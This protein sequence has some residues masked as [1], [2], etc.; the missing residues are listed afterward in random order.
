M[1]SPNIFSSVDMAQQGHGAA[2]DS[3]YAL[4]KFDVLFDHQKGLCPNIEGNFHFYR[5]IGV[6]TQHFSSANHLD[7]KKIAQI[8]VNA[9]KLQEPPG[10]CL[11][12]NAQTGSICV[13]SEIQALART[14]YFLEEH[15]NTRVAVSSPHPTH[16]NNSTFNH[17]GPS[18]KALHGEYCES[19][20][21]T[22]S[23]DT[24]PLGQPQEPIMIATSNDLT[25]P[26]ELSKHTTMESS[27]KHDEIATHAVFT[28]AIDPRDTSFLNVDEWELDMLALEDADIE[29]DLCNQSHALDTHTSLT[30]Y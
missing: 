6:H 8:I 3:R 5:M 18:N 19:T 30:P 23:F 10:R 17:A 27:T 7:R 21:D 14:F 22:P 9:I 26:L 13:L 11:Q 15:S 24:V 29:N 25:I 16:V 28:G 20:S 4:Q 12:K 2:S 1:A